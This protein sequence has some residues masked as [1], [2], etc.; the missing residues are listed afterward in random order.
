[1]KHRVDYFGAE[2]GDA[3][4]PNFRNTDS[5]QEC[6]KLQKIDMLL[7]LLNMQVGDIFFIFLSHVCIFSLL[8]LYEIGLPFITR[9]RIEELSKK[10]ST[11]QII[12]YD[13]Y[14]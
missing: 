11:S 12:L 3:L 4:A 5:Y 10:G 14:L 7:T 8:L 2:R 9:K 6:K 13:W 1:M